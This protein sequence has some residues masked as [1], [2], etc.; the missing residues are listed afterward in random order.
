MLV[1]V[2]RDKQALVVPASGPA[3]DSTHARGPTV[4]E[5]G[6]SGIGRIAGRGWGVDASHIVIA[7]RGD[8]EI[9]VRAAFRMLPPDKLRC[10]HASDS[11]RDR[12]CGDD[13]HPEVTRPTDM[14]Q[15]FK[16]FVRLQA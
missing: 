1:S 9:A 5:R 10:D 15:P 11:E 8:G 16:L 14:T 4:V 7:F 3:Y 12:V 2:T 6:D 13:E